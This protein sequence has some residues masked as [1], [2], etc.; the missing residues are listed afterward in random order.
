MTDT[1]SMLRHLED[2]REAVAE[3]LKKSRE[4]FGLSKKEFAE[5]AGML[6]QTYGPFESGERDLS[7]RAAKLLRKHYGLSLE[8]LYFGNMDDLPT[9]ISKALMLNPSVKSDQKSSE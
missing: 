8:F 5:G 3:R 4:A 6:M 9:R 2:K 7:L 1:V